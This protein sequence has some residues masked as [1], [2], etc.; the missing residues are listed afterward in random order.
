MRFLVDAQLPRI[1]AEELVKNGHH[2]IH[3]RDLPLENHTSDEE[4][5]QIADR[6]DMVVV[7]FCASSRQNLSRPSSLIPR[8]STLDPRPSTLDS[9][10]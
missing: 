10:K 2:A 6:E 9:A 8:P 3:T 4:I 1:L 5:R 7:S